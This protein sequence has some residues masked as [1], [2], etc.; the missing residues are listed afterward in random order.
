MTR[1]WGV[2]IEEEMSSKPPARTDRRTQASPA[3]VQQKAAEDKQRRELEAASEGADDV[4]IEGPESTVDSL[5]QDLLSVKDLKDATAQQQRQIA[6]FRKIV[7]DQNATLQKQAEELS[8]LRKTTTFTDQDEAL[9][10]G[11]FAEVLFNS[12]EGK[13]TVTIAGRRSHKFRVTSPSLKEALI[14]LRNA[15]RS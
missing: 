12:R 15:P 1:S 4:S 5:L 10:R 2:Q 9:L 6:A 11:M 13:Q 14:V 8:R 7:Q 3:Q